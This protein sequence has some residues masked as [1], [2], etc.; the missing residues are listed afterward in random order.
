LEN[1]QVQLSL[2]AVS[3]ISYRV[4]SSFDLI[5]WIPL[6][7]ISTNRSWQFNDPANSSLQHRFYRLVAP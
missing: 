6:T 2:S 7:S 1:D 4:D 3:T 5:I